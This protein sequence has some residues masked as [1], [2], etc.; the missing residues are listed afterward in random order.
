VSGAVLVAG[1]LDTPIDYLQPALTTPAGT[2]LD[3]RRPLTPEVYGALSW[4]REETPPDSVIAVN[5][6]WVDA[7]RRIPLEFDYS[8][9]AER[10]AFLEGWQYSQRSI[11]RG[12]AA[13]KRGA[14]P[15]AGRLQLNEA[16]FMKGNR[17]ALQAMAGYG[18]RYLVVD[19]LNG[20][21]ADLHALHRFSR[22]V[23]RIPG[24]MV[25]ELR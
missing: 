13:V 1:A 18:V 6:Q 9:F 16:A 12:Y 8:A 14:N 21:H 20:Y 5:N 19:E 7:G 24:A 10:R 2:T 3:V 23:Y 25:L 22:T 4:I 15:F 11:E 17:H